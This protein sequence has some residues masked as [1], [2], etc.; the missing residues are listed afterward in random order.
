M[1]VSRPN[2]PGRLQEDYEMRVELRL[3]RVLAK[4]LTSDDG[5]A[6]N[7]DE[8]YLL[9]A[10]NAPASL[11]PAQ[12]GARHPQDA[13]RDVWKT[14]HPN[15]NADLNAYDWT[16]DPATKEWDWGLWTGDVRA[17]QRL[18]FVV[19]MLEQDNHS[20]GGGQVDE[21]IGKMREYLAGEAGAAEAAAVGETVSSIM[22]LFQNEHDCV[23]MW[24]VT[25][26]SPD[27]A[28]I[29]SDAQSMRTCRVLR[30]KYT[31]D[32]HGKTHRKRFCDI[33]ATGSGSAYN[34]RMVI[35]P[36]NQ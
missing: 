8:L 31:S 12:Q 14:D 15:P 23:G 3:G 6:D 34:F 35:G 10:T 16:A 25:I 36:P 19:T 1:W 30:Q 18:S 33:S 21:I 29:T 20:L 26:G 13:H 2:S 9:L 7:E 22:G 28:T 32:A 4:R 17:N 5:G 24:K 11:N 27:G